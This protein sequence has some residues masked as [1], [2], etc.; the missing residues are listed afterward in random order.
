M[1]IRAGG[2]DM[3]VQLSGPQ[4]APPLL[5]LHSIG[6]NLHVWDGPAEIL[7]RGFRIVRLDLRG[8]GLT[9]VTPGPGSIAALAEDVLTALDALGIARAH[10]A[11]LSLGGMVAQTITAMAP[12]RALSLI[13][14]DTAM[15][16]P[17]PELW[18]QRAATVRAQGMAA[19][20]DAVIPRWVTPGFMNDPATS[21]LRQMLLRTD[22]EGYAAAGEAIA[23]ADL[24]A[25]TSA[26]RLPALVIVGDQDV[27]TPLAA[28][29]AMR[30]AIPGARLAVIAGASH[31]ST[32]EQPAAVADAIA[33]FLATITGVDAS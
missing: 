24:T 8:H 26:L 10:I 9:Q 19:I 3:H 28:A 18:H 22:P 7:S 13:P 2:L 15:A 17:P 20:T 33:A 4:D 25:A 6:T 21:G 32:V 16:I 23:A 14:V 5:L 11:G 30:D 29:E 12:A 27:A 31:I 1:F